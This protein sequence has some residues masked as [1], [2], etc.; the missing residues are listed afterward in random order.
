MVKTV[1]AVWENGVFRPLDVADVAIAE[2]QR[3]RLAVETSPSPTAE[4]VLQL[5][6]QV[7]EGLSEEE[8]DEI[9]QIALQ[10][11]DFFGESL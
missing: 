4:E 1:E 2:G 6:T 10:R 9:E 8:I 3:V 7:Y 5:V 11:G